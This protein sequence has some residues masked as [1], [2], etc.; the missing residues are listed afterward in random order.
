VLLVLC[1]CSAAVPAMAQSQASTGQ[2]TGIVTDTQGAA[3]AKATVTAS[4]KQ[5]GLSRSRPLTMDVRHLYEP[6]FYNV[7]AEASGFAT[8]SVKDVEVTVGRTFDLKLS[9]SASVLQE[10]INV[11]AGRSGTSDRS[12]PIP[13]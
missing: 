11:T 10:V 8:T 5:T 4:N 1:L 7:S 13:C 6:G 2:I 3:V 9:M 12:K